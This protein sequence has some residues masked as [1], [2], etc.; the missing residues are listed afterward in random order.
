MK[1]HQSQ[2][3]F[4]CLFKC[5]CKIQFVFVVF[6]GCFVVFLVKSTDPCHCVVSVDNSVVIND[7]LCN[8]SELA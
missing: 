8:S 6:F 1:I 3:L 7:V 2:H 4:L 5:L